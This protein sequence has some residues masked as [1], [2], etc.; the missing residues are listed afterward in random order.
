MGKPGQLERWV[1]EALQ[2][3]VGVA[4]V[5]LVCLNRGAAPHRARDLAEEAVQEALSRAIEIDDVEERFQNSFNYFCNWVR[6]VAINHAQD[7]LRR[8]RR[9]RQLAE[10]QDF[11][12]SP[13]RNSLFEDFLRDLNDEEAEFFRLRYMG[14]FTLGELAEL[15]LPP[16]GRS[17]N[18]RLTAMWRIDRA[19]KERFCEWMRVGEA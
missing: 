5:L 17:D 13:P 11:L 3:Q 6:R 14:R 4:A 10:G 9:N 1:K 18:G 2:R 12:A 7:I 16:D 19:L 8:E 15:L